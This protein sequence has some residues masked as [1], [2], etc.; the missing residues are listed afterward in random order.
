MPHITTSAVSNGDQGSEL[1]LISGRG[2]DVQFPKR[3]R[4]SLFDIG[5]LGMQWLALVASTGLSGFALQNGT[6]SII[7]W[8]APADGQMHRF[9]LTEVVHV[10]SSETGGA[11]QAAW[12][13]PDGTATSTALNSGTHTNGVFS[14]SQVKMIAPGSTVIYQQSSALTAG[15]AI[16][17]A[18]ILAL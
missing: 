13:A 7:S 3:A 1:A 4:S 15:A 12:T 18:E 17:Y 11:T 9:M 14:V 8:T 16:A 5:D 6:P 2:L 10:T